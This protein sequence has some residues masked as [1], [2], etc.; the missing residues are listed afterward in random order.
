MVMGTYLQT[1]IHRSAVTPT[2]VTRRDLGI[3][4]LDMYLQDTGS[5]RGPGLVQRRDKAL[6]ALEGT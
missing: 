1:T 2:T 5:Y 3:Q 4:F 6:R